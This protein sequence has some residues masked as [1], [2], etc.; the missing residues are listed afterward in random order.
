MA[1]TPTTW[2]TGDTVTSEKLNKLE[3]GVQSASSPT[4]PV[5]FT[6]TGTGAGTEVTCN[7]T[8][9]QIADAYTSGKHVYGILSDGTL[10]LDDTY[11]NT[12]T[13]VG[14]AIYSEADNSVSICVSSFAVSESGV[15]YE[16]NKYVC[17][18]TIS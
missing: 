2:Q 7:K 1:Y 18:A 13:F 10:S 15:N 16:Y 12:F 9:Q 17:S 8:Y 3:T 5:E 11:D 4:F 6:V 14:I